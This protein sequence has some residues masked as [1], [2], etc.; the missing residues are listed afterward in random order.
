[1]HMRIGRSSILCTPGDKRR[2]TLHTPS[3]R[4]YRKRSLEVRER[5]AMLTRTREPAPLT[6]RLPECRALRCRETR[7]VM[8]SR[9]V[10]DGY[11]RS[12]RR[13]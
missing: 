4:R 13:R 11:G 7:T 12:R 8:P 6:Q 5:L 10:C 3:T 2:L 1:M 9:R